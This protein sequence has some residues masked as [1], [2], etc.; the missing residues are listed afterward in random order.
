MYNLTL[1][2]ISW[3]K[4]Y[5]GK[6]QSYLKIGEQNPFLKVFQFKAIK[7]NDFFWVCEIG[8][9]GEPNSKSAP[10]GFFI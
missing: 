8:R 5:L 3:D 6:I 1:E 2:W 4:L 9:V 10:N 7:R